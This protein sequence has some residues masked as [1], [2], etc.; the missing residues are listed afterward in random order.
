MTYHISYEANP[1]QSDIQILGDGIQAYAK[2]KKNQPKMEFFA[3]FV[4]DENN[5]I[6]GG[7]SSC[8]YYGCHYIDNFWLDEN[9]RGKRFGTKLMYASEKL[10]REKG[11][12]FSTVNTMDWEALGFYQKF[13]YEIEFERKGYLNNSTFYFL[14]KE[15][16]HDATS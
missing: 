14:R 12:L 9:L 1:N 13:G 4:R 8:I 10:A 2:L 5:K 11:C 16:S 7:C 6:L 3:F 15:L